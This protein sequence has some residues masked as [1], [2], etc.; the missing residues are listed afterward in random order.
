MKSRSVTAI[1]F[2]FRV[3]NNH[4]SYSTASTLNNN[5]NNYFQLT[6]S[7]TKE[8]AILKLNQPP[9]NSFNLPALNELNNLL[10]QVEHNPDLKGVILTSVNLIFITN[11]QL[12]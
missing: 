5:N 12:K 8:Y 10:D 7:Q 1:N 6:I 9:V 11:K 4:R 2:F 3:L